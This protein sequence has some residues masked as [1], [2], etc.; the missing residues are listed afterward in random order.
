M[1]LSQ[2]F[3]III[4]GAGLSGIAALTRVRQ[5]LPNAT[6]AVFEKGDRVGGTWA[7]NTYPGLSC[8]IPSQLYSFSFALNPEWPY[9]YASQPEILAYVESV[10]GRLGHSSH[11]HLNQECTAAQWLE[12]QFLWCVHLRERESGRSYV[13]HARFL[14]T[15]VGF[16]DV[17]NGADGIR[18]IQDFE[19]RVFHSATWDHL[20]D[21]QEKNV[22]V[23]GNGCSA[24]QFVPYLVKHA[25]IQSLVQ[26]MRSPHWIDPK[27]N[28]PVPG[29]QKWT[30]GLR[31]VVRMFRTFPLSNRLWRYWL[32][33][34]L[35][36][37]FMAFRT[38]T[39]GN[40]LRK[41]VQKSLENYM[42]RTAPSEYHNILIPDFDFGAKRPVLDHGYLGVLHDQRVKLLQ[43]PSLTVVGPREIQAED[44]ETFPADVIILANGFKTQQLLTSMA[45][46]GRNGTELPEI[47]RQEGHFSSAYMGVC[48]PDFPNFFL[49]TGPNTLPAGH[50]TLVGIE[51][52]VE[53]IL[54]LLRHLW[55]ES[56]PTKRIKAQITPRA[57]EAFNDWIQARMQ[58]LVYTAS[59]RNWYPSLAAL[60]RPLDSLSSYI[61]IPG[62]RDRLSSMATPKHPNLGF[63]SLPSEIRTII[64]DKIFKLPVPDWNRV[65]RCFRDRDLSKFALSPP[66]HWFALAYTCRQVYNEATPVTWGHAQFNLYDYLPEK[67]LQRTE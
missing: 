17:P 47:W 35:D 13:K 34:K 25:S 6:V 45:I 40:T 4:I 62:I 49:L 41:F 63:L 42:R 36:L 31:Y 18:N 7:K 38:S 19:G 39:L 59:V 66:E 56:S 67:Q 21:F 48:V 55:K 5:E 58:G 11:I 33:A 61:V 10:V 1:N 3:D 23:V 30:P 15:A 22:V 54:R 24:N 43:S 32:A 52:S 29:W 57:H 26:V 64:Y 14:I 46:T 44:G 53:Y 20:F 27:E 50:S 60:K 37:A 12:D 2:D 16:C 28:D 51:C 65:K 9:V 8:D